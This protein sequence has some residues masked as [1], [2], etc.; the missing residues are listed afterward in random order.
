MENLLL[1]EE[2]K[3]SMKQIEGHLIRNFGS[4]DLACHR[5]TKAAIV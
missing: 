1:K 3:Q 2:M 5:G 4:T